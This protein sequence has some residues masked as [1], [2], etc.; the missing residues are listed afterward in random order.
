MSKSLDEQLLDASSNLNFPLVKDLLA[1]D[2][3]AG[4]QD[5]ETGHGALHK[6]VLSAAAAPAKMSVAKEMVEYLL[7]NGGVWM[8][9][10]WFLIREEE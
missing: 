2:V 1:Q 4:Y 8:Q 6:I 9:G 7:A 3:C 5:P 10:M